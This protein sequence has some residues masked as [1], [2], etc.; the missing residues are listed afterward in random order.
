MAASILDTTRNLS[1]YTIPAAWVLSIAPHFYAASLGKFDNKQPRTYTKDS[2]SDQS[3]DKATKSTIIRAEGAQQNGFENI[4][5]FAAA[6][7]IGNVAKL[8]NYTLNILSGSYLASRVVYN[9]AYINGTTDTIATL[10]TGSFLTGIG[11]IWTLFIKSGN[12][13]KNQL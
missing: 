1:L 10:R 6:V 8:D 3:I 4:G 7:V 5:L 13:L 12:I 9:L 11:I 2:E